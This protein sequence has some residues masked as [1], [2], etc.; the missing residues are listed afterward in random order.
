MKYGNI[1]KFI[2]IEKSKSVL[3][4]KQIEDMRHDFQIINKLMQSK[5]D[6]ELLIHASK[7]VE[8]FQEKNDWTT[9]IAY[10]KFFKTG[11][12][13]SAIPLFN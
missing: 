6:K 9:S 5:T 11:Y 1:E 7:K 3:T 4:Q 12:L 13:A 10:T 8:E 2:K